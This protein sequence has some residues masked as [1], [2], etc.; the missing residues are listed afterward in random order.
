[1]EHGTGIWKSELMSC[2]LQ[3]SSVMWAGSFVSL[4]PRVLVC[5]IRLESWACQGRGLLSTAE[6]AKGRQS[7]FC[8]RTSCLAWG[9]F[10]GLCSLKRFFPPLGRSWHQR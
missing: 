9:H 2:P 3:T 4:G 6:D 8:S 7:P 1:M 10:L 5:G